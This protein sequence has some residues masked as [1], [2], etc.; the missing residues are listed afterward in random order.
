MKRDISKYL[1]EWKNE[2]NR[3]P[4]LLRGARQ[5]GKTFVVNEFGKN[6]FNS[7]ILLNF[8]RNPEFKDI[9]TSNSP[10]DIIEKIAL[11]T[12]KK[13]EIGKTL[14]FFDEIQECPQ[15]I[16]SM[17]YFFEETPELHIIGAGSLLEFTLHSENF[18]L[19]VGR[20]QYL[21]MFPLSFAEFLD[22]LGENALREYLSALP[23]L[24]KLSE[25]LH[26]KLNEYIRKYFL[27]GGM[28]AVV[29]EYCTSG[30]VL[31][32]TKIQRSI[33]DTYT[34]DFAKYSSKIK[35]RY[36]QKIIEA[37]PALVGQK[38]VY[39]KVDNSIKSRELKEAAELLEMAGIIY[40]VKRTSGA[41]I[42]LE[43]NVKDNFFKTVFLDIG[44]MHAMN[45]IHAETAKEKDFIAIFKGAV[46][47][48]FTGQELIA[49]QNPATKPKLYYWARE[50]K[51]SNAEIDFLIQKNSDIVPIEIKSGSTGRLKSMTMFLETYKIKQGIKISQS[52]YQSEP[53]I[54][55]V[56]FYAIEGFM[57]NVDL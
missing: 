47:E 11:Y 5:T 1:C 7:Y 19:P 35:H 43:A 45:G 30:D 21:F 57:K 25:T 6:E 53:P 51:N 34:D 18:K 41:G 27:L 15:A 12:G 54:I 33:I 26:T 40:R 37:V 14:L 49:N 13:V 24:T 3:R 2:N 8:E 23:N 52:P 44:L 32:C 46:S 38:F 9:F 55:S 42:P 20:I 16:V 31:K 22:A 39:A 29:H 10:K 28:P 50:E 48:Q 4:L 36:L 56:P 17:R